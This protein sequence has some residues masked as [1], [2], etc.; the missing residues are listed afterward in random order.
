MFQQLLN[1]LRC[2]MWDSELRHVNAV[3]EVLDVL[4]RKL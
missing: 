2:D 4:A 3:C 1:L